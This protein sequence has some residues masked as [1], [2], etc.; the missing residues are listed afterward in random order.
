MP[1]CWGGMRTRTQD[2]D[3]TGSADGMPSSHLTYVNSRCAKLIN[4]SPP[5]LG[6]GLRRTSV[7]A[8]TTC[9]FIHVPALVSG[10]ACGREYP[11]ARRD[12]HF[13]GLGG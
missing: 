2:H 9:P 7:S 5:A 4:H 1:L 13:P 10:N 12:L 8:T 11:I 3:K 6:W